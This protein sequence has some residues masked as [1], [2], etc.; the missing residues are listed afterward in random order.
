[1]TDG[2][3]KIE[4]GRLKASYYEYTHRSGLHMLLCPMEGF[5]SSYAMFGTAYGSV[6]TVIKTDEQGDF[7]KLPEGI[8]H[9]LEHKLFECEECSA[10][11]KYAK[12]GANAN[13]FTTFDRTCYLF[14]CSENFRDSLEI[15]LDFVTHPYFTPENVEKEQGIIGQEIRMYDDSPDWRV[16]FNLLEAIYHKNPVKIDIAGTTESIAE[17]TADL[18]YKCYDTFYNLNNMVLCI[19]GSFDIDEVIET[20]DKV[21]KPADPFYLERGDCGEPDGIVK[22]Y[23]EQRLPVATTIF[24]IG[25]K[26]KTGTEKENYLG[27]VADEIFLE[28]LCDDYT[29]IYRSLYDD[30]LIN[31]T[32]GSEVFSGWNYESLLISGESKDPRKVYEKICAAFDRMVSEGIPEDL[33]KCAQRSVYGRYLRSLETADSVASAMFTGYFPGVGMYEIMDYEASLTAED[34]IDRIRKTYSSAN[35]ALSVIRPE[36]EK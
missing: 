33:F 25:F 32:F 28:A 36:E 6:D 17:I 19:A 12:T 13:A 29:D 14:G 16:F 9:Y 27:S 15:L 31:S 8:A 7:V 24:N 10:F 18:L 11:E 20:A 4:S 35:S 5:K 26:G 22:P 3:R 1:M 2:L 23:V 34:V 21:L 30:G